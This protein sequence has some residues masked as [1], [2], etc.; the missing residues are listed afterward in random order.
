G[1]SA[2]V[3]TVVTFGEHFTD[4]PHDNIPGTLEGTYTVRINEYSTLDKCLASTPD[5]FAS[6]SFVFENT[7]P[8]VSM[9]SPTNGAT[10]LASP[11]TFAGAA[12]DGDGDVTIQVCPGPT[13]TDNCPG[14]VLTTDNVSSNSYSANQVLGTGQYT[15]KA[16]QTDAAGNVGTSTTN[17]F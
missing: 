9:T 2:S 5:R 12:N 1:P 7:P 15:A 17:T 10:G 3:E 16:T 8:V 13:W 6:A 11:V 14:Q 4:P